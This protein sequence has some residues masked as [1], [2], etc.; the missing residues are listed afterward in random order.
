MDQAFTSLL[1]ATRLAACCTEQRIISVAAIVRIVNDLLRGTAL[2]GERAQITTTLAEVHTAGDTLPGIAIFDELAQ[3]MKPRLS[4][5][6]ARRFVTAAAALQDLLLIAHLLSSPVVQDA[7]IE[8][9]NPRM[10]DYLE[11]LEVAPPAGEPPVTLVGPLR[12]ARRT[13][14]AG[15]CGSFCRPPNHHYL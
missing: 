5:D 14:G 4:D 3:Q 15:S 8:L 10:L 2:E 7:T 9:N 13:E 6:S 11:R 12:L 1:S